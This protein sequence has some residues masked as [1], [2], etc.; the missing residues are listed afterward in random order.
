VSMSVKVAALDGQGGITAASAATTL[1]NAAIQLPNER[2]PIWINESTPVTGAAGYAFWEAVCSGAGCTPST[3]KL[4]RIVWA[5]DPMIDQ[6]A[7]LIGAG[8]GFVEWGESPAVDE[9]IPAIPPTTALGDGLFTTVT[10]KPSSSA[11]TLA[12]AATFSGSVTLAHD[13]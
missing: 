7:S 2:S 13:D 12:K 9:Q 4:V 5:N 1:A 8:T 6:G 10:A 3:Y 11:L